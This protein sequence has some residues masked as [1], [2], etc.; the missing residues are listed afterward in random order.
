[1]VQLSD[2]DIAEPD[3]LAFGLQGDVAESELQRRARREQRLG[4]VVA[5]IQVRASA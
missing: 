3:G 4:V 2:A 1:M 5:R